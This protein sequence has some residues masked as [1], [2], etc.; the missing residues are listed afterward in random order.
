MARHCPARRPAL[1]GAERVLVISVAVSALRRTALPP[2]PA[3]RDLR[4]V[5]TPHR[6]PE[7]AERSRPS[8]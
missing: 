4:R 5:P 3:V 8:A 2:A 1:V 7:R 6:P